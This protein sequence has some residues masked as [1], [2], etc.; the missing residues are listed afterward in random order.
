[1]SLMPTI[2]ETL[3]KSPP[4]KTRFPDLPLVLVEADGSHRTIFIPDP[5]GVFSAFYVSDSPP[6]TKCFKPE[7]FDAIK[8]NTA[9]KGA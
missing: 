3:R 4:D 5:R 6:G 2:A 1:M 8:P 7:E 9:V